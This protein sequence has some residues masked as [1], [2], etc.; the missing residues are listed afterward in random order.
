M[1]EEVNY[2]GRRGGVL[3][4]GRE[5]SLEVGVLEVCSSAAH[6]RSS[7]RE[8]R[9]AS[10]A[11]MSIWHIDASSVSKQNFANLHTPK[12]CT[13][14][15]STL[16]AYLNMEPLRLASLRT[17]HANVS[18]LVVHTSLLSSCGLQATKAED[19]ICL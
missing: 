9:Q 18:A 8:S 13:E 10:S 1:K 15:H 11:C 7:A 16:C 14:L 12:S 3:P 5:H 17:S 6:A 4:G 2:E 19:T